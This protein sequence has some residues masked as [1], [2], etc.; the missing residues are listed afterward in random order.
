MERTVGVLRP[1]RSGE[2]KRS[3]EGAVL[4]RA[5]IAEV[6]RSHYSALLRH[7]LRMAYLRNNQRLRAAWQGLLS[8][9]DLVFGSKREGDSL[10]KRAWRA[11]AYFRLRNLTTG[12]HR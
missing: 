4:L 10:R 9:V 2:V 8:L 12:P 3:S 5:A 11:V 1:T 6:P 7:R